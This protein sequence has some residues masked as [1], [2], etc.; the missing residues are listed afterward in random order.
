MLFCFPI[1]SGP[2]FGLPQCL[3]PPL[4]LHRESILRSSIAVVVVVIVVVI[5]VVVVVVIV[6]DVVLSKDVDRYS[7][8]AA[9][10]RT[11][12]HDGG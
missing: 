2:T 5:V 7:S 4:C 1:H 3:P 10:G 9:A 6:V 11:R 8:A 12:K